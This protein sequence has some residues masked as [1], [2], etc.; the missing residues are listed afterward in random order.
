MKGPIKQSQVFMAKFF[1]GV[2]EG[3]SDWQIDNK[4]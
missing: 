2:D 3:K 4:E 1:F